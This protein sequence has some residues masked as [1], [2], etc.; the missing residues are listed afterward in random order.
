MDEVKIYSISNEYISYLK[1]DSRLR[2]VFQNKPEVHIRKYLGVVLRRGEFNYFVPFSSPKETDYMIVNGKK[3]VR[4]SIIPIIRMTSTDVNGELELKGTLKLSN[5]IP[6][7]DSELTLYDISGEQDSN[8][9]ILLEKEW[10]FIRENTQLIF[11]NAKVLYNQK[12]KVEVLYPDGN[13]PRYLT[14]A[15]DF[16]YAEQKCKAFQ[17]K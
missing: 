13:A 17:E 2:N 6:V 16:K 11:K 5:M 1:E 15:I 8:Y 9:K 3:T 12:T 7:P 14:A 10:A 4:K